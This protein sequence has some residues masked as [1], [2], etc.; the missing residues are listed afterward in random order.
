MCGLCII[1][2]SYLMEVKRKKRKI[3]H[4]MLQDMHGTHQLIIWVRTH[5]SIHIK[6]GLLLRWSMAR[7]IEPISLSIYCFLFQPMD[8]W[9]IWS[10]SMYL[11]HLVRLC[12]WQTK[13]SKSMWLILGKLRSIK[14][15][16]PSFR[17]YLQI[18]TL[19]FKTTK[20]WL[21]L[22][23]YQSAIFPL[24]VVS[25]SIMNPNCQNALRILFLYRS[26]CPALSHLT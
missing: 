18:L 7:L 10:K 13:W 17:N 15:K 12:I 2:S 1:H 6:F 3:R 23:F 21:P 24:N 14:S 11:M 26:M 20:S 9:S 19:Q 5:H 8:S 16:F 22:V 25:F 4:P